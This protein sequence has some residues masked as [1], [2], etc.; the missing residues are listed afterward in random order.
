[1]RHKWTLAAVLIPVFV[2]ALAMARSQWA[3][4]QGQ[5]WRFQITGYDPRDLLRGKYLRYELVLD[6][7]PV[8]ISEEVGGPE[9]RLTAC[10]CLLDR[11]ADAGTR[12][13]SVACGEAAEECEHFVR[14]PSLLKAERFYVPEHQARAL[15]KRLIAAAQVDAAFITVIV[16]ADGSVAVKDLWLDG[17]PISRDE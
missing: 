15:E 9:Q 2:L 5:E 13:L 6:W 12:L 11:G 7:D 4:S 10:A 1:M 14:M 3:L 17:A 16:Q 8:P